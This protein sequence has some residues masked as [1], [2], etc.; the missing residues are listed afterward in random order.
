MAFFTARGLPSSPTARTEIILSSLAGVTFVPFLHSNTTYI[1]GGFSI[2][3]GNNHTTAQ[4][5]A[6]GISAIDARSASLAARNSCQYEHEDPVVENN[7]LHSLNKVKAIDKVRQQQMQAWHELLDSR[8]QEIVALKCSK[9]G[10]VVD[11]FYTKVVIRGRPILTNQL[12]AYMRRQ[13]GAHPCHLQA[14]SVSSYFKDFQQ[15]LASSPHLSCW[16][17][18][19]VNLVSTDDLLKFEAVCRAFH[20]IVFRKL[21]RRLVCRPPE[22]G[23]NSAM[24][25]EMDIYRL[26]MTRLFAKIVDFLPGTLKGNRIGALF[27]FDSVV[28]LQEAWI[29][30]FLISRLNPPPATTN[31]TQQAVL[32]ISEVQRYV[33]WAIQDCL[34]K[35]RKK[36]DP[37]NN[38]Q[39]TVE[40]SSEIVLVLEQMRLF[41]QEAMLDDDYVKEYYLDSEQIYN[42][43]GLTLVAKAMFP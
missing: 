35:W 23:A 42:Q 32:E 22:R 20:V 40:T 16:I 26:S 25:A 11:P 5:Y 43:G 8:V 37:G 36:S 15:V 9:D 10:T 4:T 12:T 30:Q 2:Q 31:E 24:S 14:I 27:L 1:E 19:L 21:I 3:R 41:H 29:K 28:S 18:S 7:Q 13:Y 17:S 38:W 33:G 6:T 39:S 34:T